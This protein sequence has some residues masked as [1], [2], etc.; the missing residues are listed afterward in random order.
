MALFASTRSLAGSEVK[1][2]RAASGLQ[3]EPGVYFPLQLPLHL[4]EL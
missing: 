1:N 2:S 4:L 3:I